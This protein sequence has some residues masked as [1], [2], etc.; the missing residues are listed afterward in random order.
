MKPLKEYLNEITLPQIDANNIRGFP[1]T[2]KRQKIANTVNIRN[3]KFIPFAPSNALQVN[4]DS[5]SN[6]HNYKTFISFDGVE[7]QH[8]PAN[9]T[10]AVQ[11]TDNETHNIVPISIA[12]DHVKLD[13][14]CADYRFRFAQQHF[15]NQSAVNTPPPAHVPTTD[16]PP[17]NP[18]NVLGA[19]KHIIA[20]EN[21]LRIMRIIR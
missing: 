13:C 10:I 1:D 21:K 7:Y 19:C 17:V 15:K 14:T 4:C 18:L 12:Q 3:I 6:G 8:E 20:L 9:N 16:R 2:Q 11:G 5:Q